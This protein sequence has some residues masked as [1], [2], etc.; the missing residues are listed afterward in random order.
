MRQAGVLAAAGVV[1]LESMVD[2]LRE[3]HNK[4]RLL[5]ETLV[6]LPGISLDYETPA[7]NMIFLKLDN[8]APISGED[9]VRRFADRGI[10]INATPAGQMRLVIHYWV[11]D[12][13]LAKVTD[14]FKELFLR[15]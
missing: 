10:R 4:A 9:L 15:A 1:A 3:D 13:A 11:D 12:E 8:G 2:R 14:A 5:A 6:E 7:T